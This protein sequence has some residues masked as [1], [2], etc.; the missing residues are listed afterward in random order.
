MGN[1]KANI[2][3]GTKKELMD[4]FVTEGVY[5]IVGL[6]W[7]RTSNF[8]QRIGVQEHKKNRIVATVR[9]NVKLKNPVV[10]KSPDKKPVIVQQTNWIGK[11][12]LVKNVNSKSGKISGLKKL[13]EKRNFMASL[14]LYLKAVVLRQ[15]KEM[16]IQDDRK[17]LR[18][19]QCQMKV[20]KCQSIV[21]PK[22]LLLTIILQ[23][24]YSPTPT[25]F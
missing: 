20:I 8:L 23:L 11:P 24:L 18:N 3:F 7:L 9:K 10:K 14:C 6:L 5:N 13:L 1:F 15:D 22:T 2:E 12:V 19:V 17:R 4:C 21:N 25:S 16:V